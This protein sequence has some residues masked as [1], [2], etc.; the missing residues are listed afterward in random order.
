M[1][2]SYRATGAFFNANFFRDFR[3]AGCAAAGDDRAAS[4]IRVSAHCRWAGSLPRRL[5]D[6]VSLGRIRDR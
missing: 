2:F 4:R 1:T 3:G 6:A 5:F